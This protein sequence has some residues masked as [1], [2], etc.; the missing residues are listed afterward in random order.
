MVQH[1]EDKT[2]KNNKKEN[3]DACTA[4][5][6]VSNITTIDRYNV[7]LHKVAGLI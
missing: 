6:A 3:S 7:C 2:L 1:W 4:K 5:I